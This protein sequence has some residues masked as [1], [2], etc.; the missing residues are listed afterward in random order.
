ML[1]AALTVGGLLFAGLIGG[2]VIVENIFAR[3]GSAARSSHAVITRTT[4]SSRG[5][6]LVLGIT[7]VVVNAI[8]D[9]LLGVVDPRS[10]AK[11]A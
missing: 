4:R 3:P 5:S 9:I 10:L 1:T 6:S 11:Q 7:V 8:V 2:A